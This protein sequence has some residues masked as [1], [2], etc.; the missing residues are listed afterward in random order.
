[1]S[2]SNLKEVPLARSAFQIDVDKDAPPINKLEPKTP[3]WEKLLP[4]VVG[5]VSFLIGL[6][7]FL[8]TDDLA[9]E[10]LNVADLGQGPA[11]SDSISI[12]I[13]GGVDV[14]NFSLNLPPLLG[15]N[16]QAG[17]KNSVKVSLIQ[18]DLSFLSLLL[19]DSL[20]SKIKFSNFELNLTSDLPLSLRGEAIQIIFEGDGLVKDP[21]SAKGK[22]QM[23][24]LNFIGNYEGIIPGVGEK[25]GSFLI[26]NIVGEMKLKSNVLLIQ[27]LSIDSPLFQATADGVLDLSR[28]SN[29]TKLTLTLEPKGFL[30][31]Y[32]E[33]NLDFVLKEMGVLHD[34]GKMFYECRGGLSQCEFKKT[35]AGR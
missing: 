17:G 31:K 2:E 14:K 8:P 4:Y 3:I 5:F 28:S 22:L 10:F 24:G 34:D 23:N 16:A 11:Q 27:E 7:L 26:S 30:Q 18:G 32:A 20:T 13:W 15:S 19:L 33:N 21:K 9:V 6:I 25:L 1:M 29:R 35:A 12:S